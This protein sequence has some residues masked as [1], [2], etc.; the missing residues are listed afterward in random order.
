[1]VS[2]IPLG[3]FAGIAAFFDFLVTAIGSLCNL[4]I[5]V[6]KGIIRLITLI[7]TAVEVLTV[8]IGILPS[9][10]AGFASITITVCVI[11]LL[12]GRDQGGGGK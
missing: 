2:V 7:P 12:A 8:S 3:V 11:F 4:A 9:V 5:S 10:L 1:M 6:V